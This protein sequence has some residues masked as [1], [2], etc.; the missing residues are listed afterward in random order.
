MKPCGVSDYEV[1][2]IASQAAFIQDLFGISVGK[3]EYIIF[4]TIVF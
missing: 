4:V 1:E 3:V 2:W